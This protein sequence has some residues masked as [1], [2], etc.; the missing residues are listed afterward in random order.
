MTVELCAAF[1]HSAL[2]N[3][4]ALMG[5][6]YGRECYCGNVLNT[7]STP[8]PADDCDFPCGGNGDE[9]CGAG[10][11]LN[12]YRFIPASSS[13]S[14]STALSSSTSSSSPTK[15]SVSS[16]ASTSN[17][18]SKTTSTVKTS[19]SSTSTS[20]PPRPT[21]SGYTYDGMTTE[22]CAGNCSAYAY[23]GT[24][25]GRECYCGASLMP[26]TTPATTDN[27]CAIPCSGN[28]SQVCGDRSKIS[29]WYSADASKAHGA[30]R[31]VGGNANYTYHGCV[32]EPS[33]ARALAGGMI[34]GNGM[35]VQQCLA[36]AAGN[37]FRYAGLEYAREC[38]GGNAIAAAARNQ[39]D[40]SCSMTCAGDVTAYCGGSGLL[41]TYVMNVTAVSRGMR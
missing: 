6:Q 8:A 1:C 14:S 17:S 4:T 21:V 38:Y 11:R 30:P 34:A 26:S 5:V 23:F 25:Y 35:T 28:S 27:Q 19:S 32:A 15:S 36:W 40:A 3:G 41:T 18:S 24:E 39:T 10:S 33:G 16:S 20:G 37:G 7:G 22:S 13:S 9:Y 12:L 31:V 29:V 2:A